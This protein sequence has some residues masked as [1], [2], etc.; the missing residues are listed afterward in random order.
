MKTISLKNIP[1][2]PV[3]H[4]PEILKRVLIRNGEI[5]NI[6][7]LSKA[8]FKPGQVAPSHVHQDMYEVFLVEFGLGSISIDNEVF[9]L[10][11]GT[12]VTVQ[13]GESHELTNTGK[14]DLVITILGVLD[15]K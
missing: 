2:E 13:P 5:P 9:P 1:E 10:K 15:K 4:N 8:T 12:C 11:S 14:D 3:S 6:T 7:Q